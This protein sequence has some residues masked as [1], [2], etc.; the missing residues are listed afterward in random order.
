MKKPLIVITVDQVPRQ[1]FCGVVIF[2]LNKVIHKWTPEE[3]P[4]LRLGDASAAVTAVNDDVPLVTTDHTDFDP[5][6]Q[7]RLP[8]D[9]NAVHGRPYHRPDDGRL[10]QCSGHLRERKEATACLVQESTASMGRL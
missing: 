8:R 4:D 9:R 1:A 6:Q 2:V 3:G 5:V 10:D 7:A